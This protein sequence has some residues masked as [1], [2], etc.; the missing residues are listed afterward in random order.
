MA[1]LEVYHPWRHT[2]MVAL[3]SRQAHGGTSHK[4][5]KQ[6]FFSFVVQTPFRVYLAPTQ[7][8][9]PFGPFSV[10]RKIRPHSFRRHLIIPLDGLHPLRKSQSWSLVAWAV[11]LWRLRLLNRHGHLLRCLDV[12]RGWPW[13]LWVALASRT[14]GQGYMNKKWPCPPLAI[15]VR[16]STPSI[17]KP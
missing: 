3:Y 1:I 7:F 10:S 17:W 4:A 13:W 9:R 16:K 2:Q 14:H 8:Q 15:K 5:V 12:F 11:G 6:R